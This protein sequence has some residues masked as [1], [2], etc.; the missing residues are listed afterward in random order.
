[1]GCEESRTIDD[2]NP[3]E[4]DVDFIR[5]GEHRRNNGIDIL[6]KYEGILVSSENFQDTIIYSD[7]ELEEKVRAFIATK[8]PDKDNPNNLEPNILDD[9]LT[10]S[11]KIDFTTHVVIAVNGVKITRIQTKAGNYVLH[12]QGQTGSST[13]YYAYVV[14]RL[15]SKPILIFE[16]Q[17]PMLYD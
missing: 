15:P 11:Y 2:G 12:H 17:K 6:T 10:R 3:R 5:E 13:N 4:N 14:K 9:I 1:M 8:I 7:Q 16:P